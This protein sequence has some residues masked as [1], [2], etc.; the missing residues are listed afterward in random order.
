MSC[1]RF[2]AAYS[3]RPFHCDTDMKKKSG[4]AYTV[5]TT[6]EPGCHRNV[7]CVMCSERL[8]NNL[9]Y[10]YQIPAPV[11]TFEVGATLNC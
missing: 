7:P 5:H 1:L 4:R 9:Q 2:A 11:L 8:L 10:N 6:L 3:Q